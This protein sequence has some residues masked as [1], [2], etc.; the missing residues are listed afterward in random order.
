MSVLRQ[1]ARRSVD[2]FACVGWEVA[3]GVKIFR[4]SS[5]LLPADAIYRQ[6]PSQPVLLYRDT[7]DTAGIRLLQ[8]NLQ[9]RMPAFVR[10]AA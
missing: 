9:G 2:G 3:F 7:N 8:R 1:P 4:A 5:G 10:Q 6:A